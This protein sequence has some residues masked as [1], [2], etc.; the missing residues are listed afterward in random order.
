[1]P[2]F[3]K[4]FPHISV[5][6]HV[7]PVV[8]RPVSPPA[9]IPTLV[10]GDGEFYYKDFTRRLLHKDIATQ[11]LEHELSAQIQRVRNWGV[12]ISH[13][14]SH[15]NQ[16]LYPPYFSVFLALMRK[17]QIACMRTHAHFMIADSPHPR[18]DAGLFYL[19]ASLSLP[20]PFLDAA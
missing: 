18:L 14:D 8:G 16:H 13:L 12:N 20:H 15:Q 11:E 4:Q 6:V 2:R 10:N 9:E 1:M 17:H 3:V 19:P 5:G 7:N